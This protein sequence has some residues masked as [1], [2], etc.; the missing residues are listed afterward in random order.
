MRACSGSLQMD[1]SLFRY[2]RMPPSGMKKK[3]ELHSSSASDFLLYLLQQRGRRW[4]WMALYF[5]AAARIS[6]STLNV[7][8]KGEL[9]RLEILPVRVEGGNA[10]A[11]L[12]IKY[13]PAIVL[14]FTLLTRGIS[15]GIIEDCFVA[16]VVLKFRR[17]IQILNTIQL[18]HCT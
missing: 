13:Y 12:Y 2:N 14:Y 1:H 10:R 16:M 7:S 15:R 3:K 4:W 9:W 17:E 11:V 6:K 8:I 18:I 5:S